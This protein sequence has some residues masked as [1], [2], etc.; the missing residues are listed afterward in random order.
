ME[1]QKLVFGVN[2]T[3]LPPDKADNVSRI[4]LSEQ[5]RAV[6]S[7][8]PYRGQFFRKNGGWIALKIRNTWHRAQIFGE[9]LTQ[10]KDFERFNNFSI[11]DI[12]LG[13]GMI[14]RFL[15]KLDEQYCWEL[16]NHTFSDAWL[17]DMTTRLTDQ[18]HWSNILDELQ[19]IHESNPQY[20]DLFK[21]I[22]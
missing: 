19:I 13:N 4:L 14:S 7:N 12:D 6:R 1:N 5:S 21:A 16:F 17:N 10:D 2:P 15:A 22:K 8:K 9:I 20:A 18:S 3:R 11:L